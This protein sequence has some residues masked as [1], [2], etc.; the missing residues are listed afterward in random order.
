MKAPRPL[1]GI[2]W[3]MVLVALAT[4]SFVMMSGCD[5]RALAFFLQNEE[6]GTPH[7]GPS[8]DD[9]KLVILVQVAGSA[10][11]ASESLE[12]DLGRE[13]SR[14]LTE[15]GKKIK[16][17]PMQKVWTWVENNP[18]WTDPAELAK[19]FEADKV[20][21]LEVESFQISN[22]GDI[23]MLQGS[24]RI[25]VT[26]HSLD[27]PKNSKGKPMKDQEK[28]SIVDY[29]NYTEPLFPKNAPISRESSK[30]EAA[31]LRN[32]TK[33]VAKEISWNFV[34]TPLGDDIQQVK[35]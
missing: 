7:E 23:Q 21:F 8:L 6:P 16:V 33:L 12:H 3:A 26:V 27:Y 15:R 34:D 28:E 32:F 29:D 9:K 20:I 19:K 13:V 22:P 31:F 10:Q 35:F 30:S 1:A 11:G 24:A 25:H 5:P 14:I 17:V 18:T 2:R 4:S